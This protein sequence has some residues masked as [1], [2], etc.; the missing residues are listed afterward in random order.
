MSWKTVALEHVPATPWRNGGG[1][2]RE[3]L[4]WPGAADWQLRISVAEV[5]RDGPFSS[6]PGIERWFAVL[7]GAGVELAL[8]GVQ[9]RLTPDSAPLRFDGAAPAY[10]TLLAGATRDLNLMALPGRARLQRAAGRQR[11]T[12]E[13]GRLVALYAPR[14]PAML[15]DLPL[16]AA[17]LAWRIAHAP[18]AAALACE[19]AWWME[20]SL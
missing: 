16:P 7:E 13:A 9:H 15:D 17:T 1:S 19:Q 14:A 20:V 4:A 5:E 2:T 18:G 11:L 10:C 8:A 3:L 12:W 6:F